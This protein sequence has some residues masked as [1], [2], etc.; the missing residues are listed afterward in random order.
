MGIIVSCLTGFVTCIGE[1]IIGIIGAILDCLECVILGAPIILR[2]PH[3][4]F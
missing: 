2:L 4:L 1:C 3:P